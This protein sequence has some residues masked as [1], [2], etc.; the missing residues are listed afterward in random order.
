[1]YFHQDKNIII[2]ELMF[3]LAERNYRNGFSYRNDR[4]R[5]RSFFYDSQLANAVIIMQ[6][7]RDLIS[8]YSNN[9]VVS[10][11]LGDM[12]YNFQFRV[13]WIFMIQGVFW[14]VLLVQLNDLFCNKNNKVHQKLLSRLMYTSELNRNMKNLVK[15][16]EQVLKYFIGSVAFLLSFFMLSRYMTM[17]NL[18][19][20]GLFWSIYF[21]VCCVAIIEIY[22]WN[23]FYFI[24]YCNHA[25]FLLRDSNIKITKFMSQ[26]RNRANFNSILQLLL[27]NIDI[28]NDK[29]VTFNNMWTKFIFLNWTILAYIISIMSVPVIF[30]EVNSKVIKSILYFSMFLISFYI[31]LI[32]IFCSKVHTESKITYILLTRLSANKTVK[33][34][35]ANKLDVLIIFTLQRGVYNLVDPLASRPCP[36]TPSTRHIELQSKEP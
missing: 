11:I 31:S 7:I 20:L 12:V 27:V 16:V 4:F 28:V 18:F 14:G 22:A 33:T 35:F 15:C 10:N 24:L 34:S 29:I 26:N 2:Q 13:Q 8:W 1:M 36:P 5:P 3:L 21:L 23:L 32:A 6:I 17:L 30:S 25:K 19:T 9:E